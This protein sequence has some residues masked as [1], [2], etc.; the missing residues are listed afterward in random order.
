MTG[1]SIEI[2]FQM[3][4]KT[5]SCLY[6]FTD[7]STVFQMESM[8]GGYHILIEKIDDNTKLYSGSFDS[9]DWFQ[10]ILRM[11]GHK[12]NISIE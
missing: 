11:Y 6:S 4:S 9:K 1:K 12:I 10:S 2:Y 5:W 7:N 3:E 8:M